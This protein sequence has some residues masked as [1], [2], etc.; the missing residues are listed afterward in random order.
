[1]LKTLFQLCFLLQFS[2]VLFAIQLCFFRAFVCGPFLISVVFF[3]NSV[4]Q[5][6]PKVPLDLNQ[7]SLASVSVALS[8]C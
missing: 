4:V 5:S 6:T 1:M 3:C 8:W 7:K 2:C